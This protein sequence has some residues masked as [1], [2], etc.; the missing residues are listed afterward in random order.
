MTKSHSNE[1]SLLIVSPRL[2]KLSLFDFT[3]AFTPKDL[4][5]AYKKKILNI[6]M[7]I[8][9]RIVYGMIWQSLLSCPFLSDSCSVAFVS[10]RQQS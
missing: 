6:R 7:A 9:E 8:Y 2:A 1:Q 3:I 10:F 4:C 5:V